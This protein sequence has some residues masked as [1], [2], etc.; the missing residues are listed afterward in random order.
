MLFRSNLYIQA[1]KVIIDGGRVS[2]ECAT[3][4]LAEWEAMSDAELLKLHPDALDIKAQYGN[5]IRQF[6]QMKQGTEGRQ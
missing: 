3:H 2:I 4:T 6:V 5:I 1:K